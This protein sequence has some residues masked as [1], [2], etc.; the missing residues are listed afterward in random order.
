VSGLEPAVVEPLLRGRLGRPYTFVVECDSTQELARAGAAAEGTVVATDHQRA[1]RGRAG[2]TWEDEPGDALLFSLVLRPPATPALPQLS[3]VVALAVAEAA[4]EVAGA[5]T[6]IKWPNDV[7]IDGAKIAGVLLE[8]SLGV[9]TIGIG[10]NVNQNAS[11]LPADTRRPAGSLRSAT[12]GMHDR[13][14]LLA[15]ILDRLERHYR[16]WLDEGLGA[17]VPALDA[18]STLRGRRVSVGDATGVVA[19]TADDGR[20]R[21]VADDRPERLVESGEITVLD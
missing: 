9:V 18:R 3:L 10:V 4:E 12:G 1:G 8:A 7:E 20:L 21:L 2:R 15:A 19:G 17:L 13:A 5:R 6:G 11:R 14:V 16:A